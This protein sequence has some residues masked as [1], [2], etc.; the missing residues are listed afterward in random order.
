M[1]TAGDVGAIGGQ[2]AGGVLGG[3]IGEVFGPEAV[4]PGAMAGR[5]VGRLAGRAF[6]EWL[7]SKMSRVESGIDPLVKEDDDTCKTCNPDCEQLEKDMKDEMYANKRGPDGG[8][9][10]G[11]QNRRFEQICGANGPD[12]TK[13][14][15]VVKDGVRVF[16][17]TVPWE[18]HAKEIAIQQERLRR[19]RDAFKQLN[20]VPQNINMN[21]VNRMADDSFNPSSGDWLGPDNPACQAG[22]DLLRKYNTPDLPPTS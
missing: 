22:A 6:G 17:N 11:L 3:A 1:T 14:G 9:K 13:M 18:T 21:E 5:Y 12:Q 10:H 16:R 15:S 2:Y 8:G 7:A 20:C 19:M 4:V